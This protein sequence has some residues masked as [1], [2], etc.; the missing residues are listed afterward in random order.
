M[1]MP[2]RIPPIV[3]VAPPAAPLRVVG[4]IHL[5]EAYPAVVEAF[6]AYV[7]SLEGSGGTL[8]L[9]GDVFEVWIG[10]PMQHDPLPRRVLAAV[11]RLIASGTTVKY[12]VGNRDVGFRGADGFDAE[13]W[14]DPVRTQLGE[15]TV[16]FTHGDQLCTVDHAYQALRRFFY[17][18]GGRVIEALPY[19][20]KHWLGTGVRRLSK[21]ETGKKRRYTMGLDYAEA[22]R[23]LEAYAADALV[24]GHVHTGVH[25]RHPGPPEREVLVLKDWERGGSVITW[26]GQ[27]LRLAGPVQG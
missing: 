7:A 26:D 12:V 17:G 11:Q 9:L 13:I 10:R 6:L 22:L 20:A 15:L 24:A 27:S 19:G 4:D 25:H 3:D 2:R 16:V 8:L 21:R 14:P 23:W 5:S 1:S 18:P